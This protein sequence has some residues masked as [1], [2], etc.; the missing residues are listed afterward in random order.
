MADVRLTAINPEDSQVYPVA[1]NDKGELLLDS[2]GASGDLDVTGN[3]SVAGSSTF[4]GVVKSATFASNV[5]VGTTTPTDA[6]LVITNST[7]GIEGIRINDTRET[8]SANKRTFDVRY[9]GTNG[10]TASNTQLFYLYDNNASSTQPFI[11]VANSSGSLFSVAADGSAK[12]SANVEV[13]NP[14]PSSS[15]SEGVELYKE[16]LV[17][18]IVSADGN[19]AVVVKRGNTVNARIKGDGSASFAGP[20]NTGNAYNV[21]GGVQA[22]PGG[23][24]YVR[25]DGATSTDKLLILLNSSDTANPVAHLNGDGSATF[26]GNVFA[27]NINFKLAPA[28][29]AAMPAPLI[30]EGFAANNELDLLSMIIEMKLQIRDLNAFMQRSLQDDPET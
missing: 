19:S 14:D 5:G 27:P 4:G 26:A 18:S 2:G 21:G 3:L 1:C 6:K 8:P 11:E 23:S 13:G 9:T 7:D 28:T 15:T 30:D 29:V 10:R 16:G 12:F 25:Q 17:S 20:I 24:L 22:F